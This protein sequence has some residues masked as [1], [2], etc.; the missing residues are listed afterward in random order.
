MESYIKNFIHVIVGLLAIKFS[1]KNQIFFNNLYF[2]WSDN[3]SERIQAH[4]PQP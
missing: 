3:N 4:K 1:F 2:L